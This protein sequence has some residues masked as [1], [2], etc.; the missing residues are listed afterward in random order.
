[1]ADVVTHEEW[2]ERRNTGEEQLPDDR[3]ATPMLSER[4]KAAFQLASEV[5]A[6][7]RRKATRI[8][9]LAHVMAVSALVMENG[10]DEDSAIAG[11]LHDAVE[12]SEDG[13]AMLEQI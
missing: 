5:H 11:L 1:M 8:P 2:L 3:S 13:E 12:D 7:Q 10:G 6:H 4:Y 9:Y